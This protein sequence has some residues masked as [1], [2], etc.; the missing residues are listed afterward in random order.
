MLIWNPWHGCHKVSEG[1]L[2]CYM[3]FLDSKRNID[4]SRVFRT[5]NFDLPAARLGRGLR[6]RDAQRNRGEPKAGRRASANPS[7]HSRPP[8]RFHVGPVHR[9]R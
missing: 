8:P 9:S 2:H 3:Y 7:V 1:C 4:T 5:E 6:E